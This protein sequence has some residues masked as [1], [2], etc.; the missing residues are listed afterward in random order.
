[1]GRKHMARF[2]ITRPNYTQI[3]SPFP[4]KENL[5]NL[6]LCIWNNTLMSFLKQSIVVE[7]IS[8]FSQWEE[9][10]LIITKTWRTIIRLIFTKDLSPKFF[11]KCIHQLISHMNMRG[12]RF[13][14]LIQ[15]INLSLWLTNKEERSSIKGLK[16][17][18]LSLNHNII[19]LHK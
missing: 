17:K 18:D 19:P 7:V 9:K 14:Q 2:L 12:K 11:N 10:Y 4:I 15:F 6:M 13:N 1:M 8:A 3:L 16:F 5:S